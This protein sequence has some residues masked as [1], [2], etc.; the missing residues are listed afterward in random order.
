MA[1]S[2]RHVLLLQGPCSWFFTYLGRALRERG[3]RVTRI[4]LCPGDR[5]F[6][7]GPGAVAYRGR[8]EGW[9]ARLRGLAARESV[10]DLVCLG[11][12]R[13]WHRA[14]ID[15]LGPT[16]IR[17]HVVEQGYLRPNWL[18]IEPDGTGG[19]SRFPATP[20]AVWRLAEAAP[21]AE[22][23]RYRTS[24]AANS[25]MDVAFNLVNLLAARLLYPHY[26]TH[27][28]DPPFRE[29][30]GWL[31]KAIRYP[32]RR[33]AAR[34]AEARIVAHAGPVFLFALQLETDFQIRLHGPPEGLR[35]SLAQ[36]I[37]S[38]ARHGPPDSLLVV[39]PHPLDNGWAPW[40]RIVAEGGPR[41]LYLDGGSLERLFLRLAGLVTVN[42]TAG[43]SALRAGVPVAALGRA[44]Y[45]LPGLTWQG[46]L[47]GFWTGAAPPDTALLEALARALAVTIQVPGNFD[48]DGAEPGASAVAER[49]LH[50]V[51]WEGGHG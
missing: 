4:L 9:P 20:E 38:H 37:R 31:G 34:A 7:R 27:A 36:V 12:G 22:P 10:T 39:K 51:F 29:W 45:G 13:T 25:A 5:L 50:P 19:N 17:I 14:A 24:F 2:G 16:G 40:A 21:P 41:C 26:R 28:L 11:D 44:I 18:T 47:D 30:A 35:T 42:S 8:P 48:G 23:P 33:A 32:W 6:W 43:F 46:G 1:A 3:A 49:V 15:T